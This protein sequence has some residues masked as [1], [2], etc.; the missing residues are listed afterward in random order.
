MEMTFP[1][2]GNQP[3]DKMKVEE[4]HGCTRLWLLGTDNGVVSGPYELSGGEPAAAPM[5]AFPPPRTAH[6]GLPWFLVQGTDVEG[7]PEPLWV[8]AS[9]EQADECVGRWSACF[10]QELVQAAT[11]DDAVEAALDLR[12]ARQA[13]GELAD[14][15]QPAADVPDDLSGVWTT[16]RR[17][18]EPLLR[19][20]V[21]PGGRARASRELAAN[22]A[23]R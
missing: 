10:W 8:K 12:R 13:A 3:P 1:I 19:R 11:R 17:Q 5:T 21:V 15:T 23:P 6:P 16:G 20:M 14:D 22:G 18:A 4:A 9:E 7:T 2:A